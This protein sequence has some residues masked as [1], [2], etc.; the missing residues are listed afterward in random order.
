[1][2]ENIFQNYEVKCLWKNSARLIFILNTY[3]IMTEK[4]D[5]TDFQEQ[6]GEKRKQYFS[7]A[8]QILR[9]SRGQIVS[10]TILIIIE[11][12]NEF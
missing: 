1:M 7:V 4:E 8:Q 5:R 11:N 2:D 9:Y 6:K 12:K 10:L 3:E